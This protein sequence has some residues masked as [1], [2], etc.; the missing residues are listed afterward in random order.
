[1]KNT[2]LNVQGSSLYE[3]ILDGSSYIDTDFF[4][5]S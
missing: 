5:Y 3:E 1:M 4:I 2:L